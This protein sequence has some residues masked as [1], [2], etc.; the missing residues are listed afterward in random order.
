[1]AMEPSRSPGRCPFCYSH[2]LARSR[3]GRWAEPA[4]PGSGDL[5]LDAYIR[6]GSR[7]RLVGEMGHAVKERTDHADHGQ[8]LHQHSADSRLWIGAESEFHRTASC[9]GSVTP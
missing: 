7:P 5:A 6:S 1:M 3:V 2:S 8:W 4:L 9:A